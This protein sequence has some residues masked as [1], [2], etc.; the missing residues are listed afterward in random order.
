MKWKEEKKNGPTQPENCEIAK[1]KNDQCF[2]VNKENV[3]VC[4]EKG[5]D[6]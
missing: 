2:I 3:Q 4:S 6:D 5:R 1:G